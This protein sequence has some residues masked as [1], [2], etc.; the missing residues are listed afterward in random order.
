[1]WYMDSKSAHLRDALVIGILAALLSDV[2]LH[3]F[4][5]MYGA[6]CTS[7]QIDSIDP[8]GRNVRTGHVACLPLYWFYIAPFI[9]AFLAAMVSFRAW[10]NPTFLRAILFLIICDVLT[11]W[12]AAMA[13]RYYWQP[14]FNTPIP[15]SILDWTNW[16]LNSLLFGLLFG[17]IVTKF[18]AIWAGALGLVW[19]FGWNA[20]TRRYNSN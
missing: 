17:N 6:T 18:L 13:L 8:N 14:T 16:S 2:F 11:T 3:L 20:I 4:H 7:Y 12:L 15:S 10:Q 1:M 5:S 19:M 9:G